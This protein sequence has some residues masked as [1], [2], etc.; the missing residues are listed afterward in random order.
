MGA[1]P[2]QHKDRFGGLITPALVDE[3]ET[4]AFSIRRWQYEDDPGGI[5]TPAL[6][7]EQETFAF[8]MCNPPFFE[9]IE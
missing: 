1:L 3:Q 9:S 5:I 2:G 8:S 6:V 7:D 4:F